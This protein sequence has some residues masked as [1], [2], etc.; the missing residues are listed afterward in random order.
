MQRFSVNAT[1]FLMPQENV[2]KLPSKVAH[3]RCNLFSSVLPTGPKA[4]P[5]SIFFPKKMLNARLMYNDFA[6]NTSHYLSQSQKFSQ[7]YRKIGP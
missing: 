4:S 2:E 3:N 1:M 7:F 5:I 6:H